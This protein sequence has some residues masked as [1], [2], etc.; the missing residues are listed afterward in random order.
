[1]PTIIPVVCLRGDSARPLR[2]H[3]IPA[4]INHAHVASFMKRTA[5]NRFF[6]SYARLRVV[7]CGGQWLG[8][9]D[10]ILPCGCSLQASRN[11]KKT[12]RI[13]GF[14]CLLLYVA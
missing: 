1:M 9:L 3:R 12:G 5:W 8:F 7:R 11:K 6:L 13:L 4:L 14:I 2:T 10:E